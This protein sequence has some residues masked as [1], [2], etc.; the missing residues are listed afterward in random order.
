MGLTQVGAAEALGLH[1][2][3]VGNY[4]RGHRDGGELVAVPRVV[5]L[6]CERLEMGDA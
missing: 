3:T 5:E 2:K 1:L 6:A 4:D